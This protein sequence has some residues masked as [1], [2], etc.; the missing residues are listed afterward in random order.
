[1][2]NL[3][4]Y[5]VIC[6]IVYVVGGFV[7]GYMAIFLNKRLAQELHDIY[8]KKRWIHGSV[9]S[10]RLLLYT[11]GIVFMLGAL[12]AAYALLRDMALVRFIR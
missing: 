2:A 9:T 12:V 8:R 4:I 1:M 5:I 7:G 3:D 6:E 10:F 11:L